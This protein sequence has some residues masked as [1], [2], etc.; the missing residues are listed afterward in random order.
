MKLSGNKFCISISA[1]ILV[2]M[3]LVPV[4]PA[5]S[6]KNVLSSCLKRNSTCDAEM[7]IEIQQKANVGVSIGREVSLRF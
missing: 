2:I 7:S 1:L 3:L 6:F 4:L 5:N